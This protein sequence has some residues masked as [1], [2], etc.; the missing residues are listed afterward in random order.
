[1][2]FHVTGGQI[3]RMRAFEFGKQVLRQ[4]TEDI[5]QHVQTAAMR[6]TDDDFLNAIGARA[7]NQV[8]QQRDQA[9]APFERKAFL[10]DV[11]GMEIFF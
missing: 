6:H 9:L 11:A 8:F 4:F 7:L 3:G 2:I 10:T 1:M 5:D